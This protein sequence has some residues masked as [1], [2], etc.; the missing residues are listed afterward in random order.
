MVVMQGGYFYVCGDAKHMAKDVHRT[1]A[2]V[3]QTTFNYTTAEA[4][5][6]VKRLGESG[7]YQKD[8]W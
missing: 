2:T 3:L 5:N 4:E 1:L 7:R 6:H 8:V